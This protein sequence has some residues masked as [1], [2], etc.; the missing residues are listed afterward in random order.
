MSSIVAAAF[1]IAIG[2]LLLYLA[3]VMAV[4]LTTIIALPILKILI[5]HSS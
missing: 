3:S 5:G 4:S 1:I 2:S